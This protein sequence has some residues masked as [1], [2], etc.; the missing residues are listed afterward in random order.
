MA[1]EA[2]ARTSAR[3]RVDLRESSRFWRGEWKKVAGTS[4][5]E[6]PECKGLRGYGMWRATLTGIRLLFFQTRRV[7]NI[8][9]TRDQ[10]HGTS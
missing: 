9:S 1:V 8:F 4:V 5:I 3:G 6:S 2:F 7:F 10:S